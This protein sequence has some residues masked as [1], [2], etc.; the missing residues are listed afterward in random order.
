M[1]LL[2][3]NVVDPESASEVPVTFGNP[4]LPHRLAIGL[5]HE[6]ELVGGRLSVRQEPL[7]RVF[8]E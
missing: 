1:R 8:R 4:E 2:D 6:D 5:D 3:L 7:E